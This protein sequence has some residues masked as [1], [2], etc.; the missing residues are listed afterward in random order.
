M[1]Y[2]IYKQR[3]IYYI[4]VR[5]H[6]VRL[7]RSLGVKE[8][9]IA[10]SIAKKILPDLIS[11]L[12]TGSVSNPKKRVIPTKQLLDKFLNHN[13][14]WKPKTREWY[15]TC[16]NKY[17]KEGLPYNASYRAM[18]VRAF[19]K[20]INWSEKHNYDTGT[21]VKLEGGRKW[22]RRLRVF[23]K[24]EMN[25][26]MFKDR[27]Y[28]EP[29]RLTN[30]RKESIDK[31][32]LFIQFAYYTGCRR[33]EIRD[34]DL[35]LLNQSKVKTKGKKYR[36]IK[37]NNQAQSVLMQMD[38]LWNYKSGYVSQTF[39]TRARALGIN[40]ARFHDIR[41]TYAYNLIVKEKRPIFEVSQLLGHSNVLTT[42]NHYAPLLVQD[43]EEFEL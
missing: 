30:K 42:Q 25:D 23:T 4:S 43:A 2:S 3:G 14:G 18:V 31:F 41:T 10:K 35:E 6:G 32:K 16:L 15:E 29:Y 27:E 37:L 11:E 26:L 20:F 9:R 8:E 40:D 36:I 38:R 24:D 21:M 1:G 28:S 34:M 12:V 19:N 33:D 22:E 7:K 5:H 13:H 39:K 17:F